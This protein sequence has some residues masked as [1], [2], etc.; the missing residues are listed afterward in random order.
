MSGFAL[1]FSKVPPV[2]VLQ[3]KKK[4]EREREKDFLS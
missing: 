4:G 3:T 1:I 2:E